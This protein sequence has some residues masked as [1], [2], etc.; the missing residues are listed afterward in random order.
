MRLQEILKEQPL[1]LD[2]LLKIFNIAKI[3][4]QKKRDNSYIKNL[5]HS[6][7]AKGFEPPTLR[8]EI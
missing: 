1:Y 3:T 5:S 4:I 7:T 2:Y 8:A 6:V